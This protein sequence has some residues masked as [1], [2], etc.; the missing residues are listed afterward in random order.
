M[1]DN[2][3]IKNVLCLDIETVPQ[4]ATYEEL[5]PD[6]KD[7]WTKKILWKLKDEATPSSLY[8]GAGIMAEFGKIICISAGFFFL[9]DT[10]LK[11]KV[12][13]FYGHDEKILLGDFCKLLEDKFSDEAS[14][15]CAHNGREFDFPYTA[16]RCLVNGIKIPQVLDNSDKKPWEVKLIDTMGLW[17]FGDYKNFT[18]LNLLAALFGIQSPKDDIDGSQIWDVYWNHKDLERI[19]IYCQKDVVTVGQILLSFKGMDLIKEENIIFAN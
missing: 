3:E 18:S 7:L 8:Q 14:N 16:R 13:S 4:Y 5:P 11:F 10:V 12:K 6:W 1:L 9:E 19:K 2:L 15:L 17:R